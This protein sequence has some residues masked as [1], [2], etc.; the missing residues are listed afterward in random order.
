MQPDLLSNL[1][2]RIHMIL[3]EGAKAG[4]SRPAFTDEG[5]AVWS[6]DRLIGTV[7]RVSSELGALGVRPGDRVLIVCENSIA[8]IVL[9]YAVSRL[10]AWSVMMNARQSQRE[11]ELIARDCRPRRIL[12]THVVSS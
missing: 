2:A 10:D 8:A 9:M 5:G 1:P 3:E 11:L 6:Y 4:R 7:E 12:Y